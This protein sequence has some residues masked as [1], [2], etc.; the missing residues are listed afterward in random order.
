MVSQGMDN[1]GAAR[2]EKNKDIDSSETS[3]GGWHNE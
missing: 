3:K 1:D 2:R